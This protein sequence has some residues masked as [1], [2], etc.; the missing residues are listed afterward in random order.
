[1]KRIFWTFI[2][3][4]AA[5][6]Y[7][8][9]GEPK[10]KVRYDGI[11][12]NQANLA[13]LEMLYRDYKYKDYLYM[14][15]KK[16]PPIFL[17]T[18][19]T[20][21]D[22]IDNAEKRNKLFL[23]I[24]IP[25]TLK[26]NEELMLERY[27]IEELIKEFNDKH[28][29]SEQQI[30]TIEEKAEKYD[31]FTRLKG[32]RRYALLLEE[33]KQKVDTIPSSL[34][35]AA[36]AIETNWG[37]NRPA[38]LANSLYRELVWYTDDGLE[39]LDETEDKSYRYKIFPS[40][41]ESLKSH[42]LKINSHVNYQQFRTRRAQ[43]R[44]REDFVAGRTV[45]YSMYFDSNLKNFAGLLDYTITFYELNNIDEAELAPLELPDFTK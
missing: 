40:L 11:Y 27:D 6:F 25:L 5:A 35:T 34:L 4:I 33:L 8:Y 21:F 23:Q 9:A 36:A 22:T 7:A 31:I 3:L 32:E 1:M 13:Q 42:A 30:K 17:E 28:D 19:P 14:P 24:M 16:Y 41:Y 44:E 43:I 2:F 38:K 37:T 45:A 39:A 15:D 12:L 18:L 10:I 26:L 20:D 29:L